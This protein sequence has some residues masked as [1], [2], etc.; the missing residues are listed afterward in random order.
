MVSV[1]DTEVV[2]LEMVQPFD[3]NSIGRLFGGRILE[4]IANVGT[5]ATVKFS[6]GPTVLAYMD[7]HFFLAPAFIGDTVTLRARVEYVGRSSMETYIEAV[8]RHNGEEVV[9]TMTT[10]SYVAVD[11]YGQPR[12]V[13]NELKP[14]PDELMI[15]NNAKARYEARKGRI[16][17]RREERYNVK[18]P[19]EGLRWRVESSRWVTPQDAF[20]ANMVSAG[21]LL[22]WID[23]IAASLASEYTKSVVVTGSIDDTIFYSPIRTGEIVRIAAGVTYVGRSSLETLIHV[24]T[25]D[26]YGNVKRVCTAYYTYVAIDDKGRPQPVPQYQPANDYERRLF[27]EGARRKAL[28]DEEIRKLKETRL[29]R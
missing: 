10:A 2:M 7:R 20:M 18:D 12:L 24:T 27:E 4:W 14:N 11:E 8:R 5:V 13:K 23:N 28:R 3:A 1:R 22:A 9:M 25:E 6:R 21:R 19:T 16:A 29:I 26:A 15:Y 17:N